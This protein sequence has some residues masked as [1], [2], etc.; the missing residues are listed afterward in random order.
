M[1]NWPGIKEQI[2]RML[3]KIIFQIRENCSYATEVSSQIYP[4]NLNAA[5]ITLQY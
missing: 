4:S 2:S 5:K 3:F 1:L